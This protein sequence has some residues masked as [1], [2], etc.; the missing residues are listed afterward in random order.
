MKVSTLNFK[1]SVSFTADTR[2]EQ[3][4]R[5][6]K[7]S[8]ANCY[9]SSKYSSP[10]ER[11]WQDTSLMHDLDHTFLH[12]KIRD[13]IIVRDRAH[14]EKIS[15]SLHCAMST[16]ALNPSIN[17]RIKDHP[18][19]ERVIRHVHKRLTDAK[20]TAEFY[21]DVMK[22]DSLVIYITASNQIAAIE[23]I[24]DRYE[25]EEAQR[26]AADLKRSI[27]PEY[28]GVDTTTRLKQMRAPDIKSCLRPVYC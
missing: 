26:F 28:I 25:D 23:P 21:E 6:L 13:I 16:H 4:R 22:A 27:R 14:A 9:A 1:K 24:H 7:R 15:L 18:L 10:K 5:T 8:R 3:S 20:H 19:A 17:S 11:Q 2:F 12:L